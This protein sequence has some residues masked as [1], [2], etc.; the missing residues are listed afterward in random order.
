MFSA[1]SIIIFNKIDLSPHLDFSLAQAIANVRKINPD[2][3]ILQVS[4]RTGGGWL[5]GMTGFATNGRRHANPPSA[6][7]GP[8]SPFSPTVAN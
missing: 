1:V 8:A 3:T 7:V 5:T 4:A 6:P 2:A